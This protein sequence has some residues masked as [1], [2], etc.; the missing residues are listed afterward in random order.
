MIGSID[1]E[2]HFDEEHRTRYCLPATKDPNEKLSL[3]SILK[4][5]IGKDLAKTGMPIELNEPLS[6]L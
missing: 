3:W 2:I 5:A 1:K 4:N 6:M